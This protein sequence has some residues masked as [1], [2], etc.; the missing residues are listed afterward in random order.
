M[1]FIS[2]TYICIYTYIHRCVYLPQYGMYTHSTHACA[3]THAWM[4]AHIVYTHVHI[5]IFTRIL[6]KDPL[7]ALYM[8]STRKMVVTIV[9]DL[10]ELLLKNHLLQLLSFA[11]G[12]RGLRE[13]WR[14]AQGSGHKRCRPWSP[15]PSTV[16]SC[17]GQ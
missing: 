11:G 15:G 5:N 17:Q 13:V 4:C 7:C 16:S 12:K 2:H 6:E 8:V 1:N 3:C 10:I 9:S 14:C